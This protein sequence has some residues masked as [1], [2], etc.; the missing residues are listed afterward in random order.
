MKNKIR[1]KVQIDLD[2]QQKEYYLHQQ[3]KAIQE[4]LGGSGSHKEIEQM[5]VKQERKSGIKKLV[6]HLTK[7]L[8]S[9]NE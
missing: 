9:Y 2:K 4:E 5:E 3:M 1:S 7:N 6:L 8:K